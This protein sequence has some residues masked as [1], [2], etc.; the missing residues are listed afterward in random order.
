MVVTSEVSRAAKL[1]GALAESR[2]QS[3]YAMT[4]DRAW[5]ALEDVEVAM[6]VIDHALKGDPLAFFTLLRESRPAVRRVL[7]VHVPSSLFAR[8]VASGVID[9]AAYEHSVMSTIMTL[10]DGENRGEGTGYS[11]GA[12]VLEFATAR[13]SSNA[14]PIGRV[15]P[16]PESK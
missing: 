16:N 15:G 11:R 9:A 12:I 13:R 2:V 5:R 10:M 6:V 4:L 3:Y 1:Q 8:E 14:A 7:L